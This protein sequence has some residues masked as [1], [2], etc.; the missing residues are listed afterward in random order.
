MIYGCKGEMLSPQES[1]FLF[2]SYCSLPHTTR[3]TITC[4]LEA[5][6]LA[7]DTSWSLMVFLQTPSFFQTTESIRGFYSIYVEATKVTRTLQ[8]ICAYG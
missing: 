4:R 2:P 6:N 3:V 1:L 8:V 7:S 5:E